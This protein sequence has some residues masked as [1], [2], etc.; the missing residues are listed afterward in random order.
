MVRRAVL[1]LS[2]YADQEAS[3]LVPASKRFAKRQQ[4]GSGEQRNRKPT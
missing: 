2:S 1:V 3:W 4:M